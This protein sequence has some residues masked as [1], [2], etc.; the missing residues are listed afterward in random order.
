LEAERWL[1]L[2]DVDARDVIFQLARQLFADLSAR[3]M[4][5]AGERW[6]AFMSDLKDRLDPTLTVEL[7][8]V[9]LEVAFKEST[10]ARSQLRAVLDP[11][12]PTLLDLINEVVG[13][14]R[15]WL[16]S[17]G[18]YDGMAVIVDQL[19]RIQPHYLDERQGVTNHVQLFVHGAGTLRGLGCDV[20]YVLPIELAYSPWRQNLTMAYAAEILS[21]PLLPVVQRDG[22]T[23]EA[24]MSAMRRIVELRAAAF[25]AAMSDLFA[26][27]ELCGEICR[28]SG[29]HMRQM[30]LLLRSALDREVLPLDSTVLGRAVRRQAVD[31]R[32]GLRAGDWRVLEAVERTKQPAEGSEDSFF[33]LLRGM[34][35]YA[36]E[37][38]YGTWYDLNPLLAV[39]PGS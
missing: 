14:A 37:D 7:G 8:Q 28:L 25:G 38:D 33:Q 18:G 17:H 2:D 12:M 13:Q 6:S 24:G 31:I 9:G 39:R 3:G 20:L 34:Y 10:T 29:G 1:D 22:T 32:L 21:W 26:S 36:Y 4:G 15:R 5:F 11:R 35:V 19:D 23:N 27:P 30:F 16:S